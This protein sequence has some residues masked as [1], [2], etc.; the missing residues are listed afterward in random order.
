MRP[1]ALTAALLA[2]SLPLSPAMARPM[3]GYTVRSTTMFAGPDFNYPAVQGLGGNVGLT[4]YGCLRDWSWCDVGDRAG[5]GWVAG[6]DIV[7][8]YQG[9]RQSILPTMGI[10]I[11][12]FVFGSYWDSHYRNRPF[13]SQRPR[14][15]QQYN[16][17]HRPQ[18]GPHPGAPGIGP[19][20][21]QPNRPAQHGVI[22]Q[23][24][25]VAP[26]QV[27]PHRPG[28]IPQQRQPG[29]GQP[30]GGQHPNGP[31]A[32][33]DM[34]RGQPPRAAPQ[35]QPGPVRQAPPARPGGADNG[36]RG[37]GQPPGQP[38][39]GPQGRPNQNQRPG[40]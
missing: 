5:R 29:A 27:A 22:Q 13:Y 1:Y 32:R 8:N 28:T 38:R 3:N 19:Q 30:G 11:L 33:P 34:T 12:S 25:N 21:G 2:A 26:R 14:F 39:G 24:P 17:D 37:N 31:T 35:H 20:R 6:N 9:R 18:W 4:V 7:V 10:G 23:R 15:E 36:N 16:N 40:N